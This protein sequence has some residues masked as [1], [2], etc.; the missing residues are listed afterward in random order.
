V[1]VHAAAERWLRDQDRPDLGQ[2]FEVLQADAALTKHRHVLMQ[3]CS[4]QH[5]VQEVF[6]SWREGSGERK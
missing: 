3:V 2:L 1:V 4:W 6:S 5:A